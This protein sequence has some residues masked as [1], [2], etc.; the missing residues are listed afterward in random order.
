MPDLW[1]YGILNF[2]KN[3]FSSS[4]FRKI[5]AISKQ[6]SYIDQGPLVLNLAKI[7]E[8]LIFF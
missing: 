7:F 1:L 4:N 2:L 8:I 5:W 6:I 3:F